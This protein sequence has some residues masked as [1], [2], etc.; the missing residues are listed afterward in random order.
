MK[1]RTE[2]SHLKEEEIVNRYNTIS[3]E[4]IELAEKMK[5]QLIKLSK[6]EKEINLLQEEIL[7]R[8]VK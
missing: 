6:L 7:N 4:Y 2:L 5:P 3:L 8:E 1:Q